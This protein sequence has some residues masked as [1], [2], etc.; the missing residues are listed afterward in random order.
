MSQKLSKRRVKEIVGGLAPHDQAILLTFLSTHTEVQP[1]RRVRW[2][3]H[4]VVFPFAADGGKMEEFVAGGPDNLPI[5]TVSIVNLCSQRFIVCMGE[6]SA[7]TAAAAE[8]LGVP[9]TVHLDSVSICA[10]DEFELLEGG[11]V[12][13]LRRRNGAPMGFGSN[14]LARAMLQLG[15]KRGGEK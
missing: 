4:P 6:H 2:D 3:K 10:L 9:P 15:V 8:R 7:S 13:L 1:S 14:D 5:I 11:Q 12:W